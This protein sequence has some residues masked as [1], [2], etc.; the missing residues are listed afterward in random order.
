MNKAFIANDTVNT[1]T[2]T[3]AALPSVDW[4]KNP[5]DERLD[6]QVLEQNT[7]PDQ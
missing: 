1:D 5:D 4:A 2:I 6:L 7:L 3:L